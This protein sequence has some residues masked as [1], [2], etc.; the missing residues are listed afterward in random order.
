[1]GAFVFPHVDQFRRLLDSAKRCFDCSFGSADKGYDGAIS[2][3]ARINV[4]Q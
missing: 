4:Q 2:G 3:S 1:V